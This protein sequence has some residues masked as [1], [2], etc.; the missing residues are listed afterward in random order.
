M[1]VG[2]SYGKLGRAPPGLGLR[3]LSPGAGRGREVVSLRCCQALFLWRFSHGGE[4][5]PGFGKAL[6]LPTSALQSAGT[7]PYASKT[8][9]SSCIVT[10]SIQ[11]RLPIICLILFSSHWHPVLIMCQAVV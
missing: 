5:S 8:A 4:L 9:F 11:E 2:S 1:C 10:P 6:S 7:L 3:G